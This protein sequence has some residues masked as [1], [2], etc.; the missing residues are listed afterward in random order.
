MLGVV[1]LRCHLQKRLVS[2]HH[3]LLEVAVGEEAV[4]EELVT[5]TGL[6]RKM[7]LSIVDYH[8]I[9]VVDHLLVGVVVVVVVSHRRPPTSFPV[10]LALPRVVVEGVGAAV[11]L[12][13]DLR[14]MTIKNI[15][16]PF[17]IFVRF[18]EINSVYNICKINYQK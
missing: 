4:G 9:E 1:G 3:L 7:T 12:E 16:K 10:A 14:I 11:T 13:T 5:E 17:L 18:K 2:P 8:L 15:V 6:R